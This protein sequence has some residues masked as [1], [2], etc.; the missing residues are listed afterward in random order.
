MSSPYDLLTGTR[1]NPVGDD[2]D[3]NEQKFLHQTPISLSTDEDATNQESGWQKVGG[4]FKHILAGAT[5]LDPNGGGGGGRVGGRQSA[6]ALLLKR[7]EDAQKQADWEQNYTLKQ[8]EGQQKSRESASRLS[9]LQGARDDAQKDREFA[10]AGAGM[11]DFYTGEAVA[12]PMPN[13]FTGAETDTGGKQKFIN[14]PG[15]IDPDTEGRPTRMAGGV[16]M[17]PRS[18]EEAQQLKGKVQDIADQQFQQHLNDFKAQPENAA[19]SKENDDALKAT[20]AEHLFGFKPDPAKL[21]NLAASLYKKYTDTKDPDALAMADHIQ[22]SKHPPKDS[23]D[24]GDQLSPAAVKLYSDLAYQE[25]GN[26][27]SFGMGGT[28]PKVQIANQLGLDHPGDSLVGQKVAFDANRRSMQKLVGNYDQLNT[29]ENVATKNINLVLQ[30]AEAL[31]GAG[32]DS[33]S[34]VMNTP[35]R[36]L[37]EK[38]AGHDTVTRLRAALQ[39]ANNE[40]AR[41]TA[42]RG[43]AG[44]LTDSARHE[45]MSINPENATM[46]QLIGAFKV[47][48]QD[49]VNSRSGYEDQIARNAG[50]YGGIDTLRKLKNLDEE[51]PDNIEDTQSGRI[52]VTT[53]KSSTGPG[54]IPNAPPVRA[55]TTFKF[56]NNTTKLYDNERDKD[57][58]AHLRTKKEIKELN[59]DG[60]IKQ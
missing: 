32:L 43:G 28:K 20:E 1:S 60:S 23:T 29:F 33:G 53:P 6:A 24:K 40:I 42:L 52:G 46:N 14:S 47:E 9:S 11:K 41:V 26:I 22:A 31:K 15:G 18:P 50:R 12:A 5:A 38:V 25:G 58:I 2:T 49:M 19:W 4:V 36:L 16:Q 39:I 55:G 10:Q 45:V 3:P 44:V 7:Q 37:D 35:I 59:P 51:N 30:Q 21:D 8:Q 13:L 27:Q 48:K 56:P 57:L 17:I 54:S 34:P